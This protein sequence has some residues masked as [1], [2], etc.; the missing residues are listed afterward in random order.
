[1]ASDGEAF[2]WV[3]ESWGH[4]LMQSAIPYVERRRRKRGH[5]YSSSEESSA[6]ALGSVPEP[7]AEVGRRVESLAAQLGLPLAWPCDAMNRVAIGS[8]TVLTARI[9]RWGEVM[10]RIFSDDPSIFERAGDTLSR[11]LGATGDE[12]R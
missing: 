5:Y 7:V 10:L 2:D 6:R 3:S 12:I 1:V 9:S 4:L 8:D 11:S